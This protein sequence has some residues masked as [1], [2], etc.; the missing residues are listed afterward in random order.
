[1]LRMV[2]SRYES[3]PMINFKLSFA[4]SEVIRLAM[5][6]SYTIRPIDVT[7]NL[8][9]NYRRAANILQGLSEQGFLVPVSGS[10]GER[11]V[12]YELARSPFGVVVTR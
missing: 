5:S 2:L 6:L 1:M 11:I 9:M 12:R 4:E 3:T 8:R 7:G 10:T